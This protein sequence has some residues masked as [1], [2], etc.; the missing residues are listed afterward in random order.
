MKPRALILTAALLCSASAHATISE[1]IGFEKKVDDAAAIILGECVNT[2]SRWDAAGK[3]IVTYSTFRIEKSM[4]GEPAQEITVVTPGGVVNGIHQETIGVPKFAAGDDRVLFVKNTR[5]GPTVLYFDQGAYQVEK[6]RGERIVRPAVSAAVLVDTQ[7]G[8][9]VAPEEP[10]TL[11]EFE[12]RISKR[13][14]ER[15]EIERMQVIERDKRA[16]AS[17]GNVLKRNKTLV[18]LALIGAILATMQLLKRW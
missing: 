12:E 7:R 2:A 13:I 15:R 1:A 8:L 6:I 9:A 10:S 5:V 14:R 18:A 16:Q 4:K 3:W 11:R 17:L